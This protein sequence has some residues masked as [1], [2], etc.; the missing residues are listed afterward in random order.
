MKKRKLIIFITVISLLSL[1]SFVFSDSTIKLI[2]NGKELKTDVP[3]KAISGRVLVPIRAISEA[4]GANITWDDENHSVI[5]NSRELEAQKSQILRLEEALAP[6]DQLSAVNTWAEGVKMRNGALQYAV[7]SPELKKEYYDSLSEGN[8]S[9]GTSSPWVE[10]YKITEKFKSDETY[11]YEVEF[12]YTDSTNSKTTLKEYITIKNIEGIWLISAIEKVDVKGKITELTFDDKKLKSIF[13]E[14]EA[15]EMGSY[16]K[17]NVII[18][19]ETKIYNGYTDIEL[20]PKDLKEGTAVEVDLVDG[21]M[22][23]IYPVQ[24]EAKTIRIME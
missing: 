5:I 22:I 17:A 16:D 11:R 4:L 13:V 14:D 18:G 19:S 12:I 8:W 20:S 9:T 15:G 2:L 1:V 6:K 23:M 21:P 3:P 24:A 7:M 10:S